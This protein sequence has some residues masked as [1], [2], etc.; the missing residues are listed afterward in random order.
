MLFFFF[1]HNSNESD[2]VCWETLYDMILELLDCVY[3]E[4]NKKGTWRKI[5]AEMFIQ[6]FCK[7][8][9]VALSCL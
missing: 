9:L 2:P 4:M 6:F 7:M 1:L 3:L 8:A 5:I